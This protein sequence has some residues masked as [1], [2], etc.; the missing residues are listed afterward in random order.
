[1]GPFEVSHPDEMVRILEAFSY[2]DEI[3]WEQPLNYDLINYY[4]QDLTADEKLLTHW[5]CNITNRQ[6]PFRRVPDVGGYIISHLVHAYAS[7]PQLSVLDLIS[8][9]ARRNG[10]K[11]VLECPLE[12][13]NARLARHGITGP[14]VH[15]AARFMPEDLLLIYRTLA[16]LDKTAARRFSIFIT[17]L[18]NDESDYRLAIRKIARALNQLTY[19]AGG[20]VS[21]HEYD[22]RI[23]GMSKEVETFQLRFDS[24]ENLMGR[25]RLWC[26][27]R[28]Y[29]KSRE[30]NENFVAGLRG[31]GAANPEVWERTKPELVAALGVLELP[32]D[33]WNNNEVFRKGL[34][35]PYIRNER[36]SWDM[37]RTVRRI[38]ELITRDYDTRF[39]PEQLD[40]SFDFA[41][42]MCQQE[43]CGECLFGAGIEGSCHQQ[44]GLL[45][46][47]VDRSCGYQHRCDPDG[48]GLKSNSVKGTCHSLARNER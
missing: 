26:S 33:V 19:V 28:D 34:F 47:V 15:F 46:P 41:P 2:I 11:I 17:A 21:A 12:D 44:S 4:K 43:M 8:S 5:L 35:S 7:Q 25:K 3:R 22:E 48:C 16:L 38:Y 42:R 10:E 18:I 40:V 1:M 30:F 45:C 39:Y 24:E 36:K 23:R 27:L 20:T 32:G 29:I 9:Y 6:T 37:P 13:P 31:A 14:T